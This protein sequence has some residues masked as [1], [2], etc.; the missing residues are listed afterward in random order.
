MPNMKFVNGLIFFVFILFCVAV[1]ISL[2]GG[3]FNFILGTY[4]LILSFY[5]TQERFLF[6]LG[7]GFFISLYSIFNFYQFFI[8]YL[9]IAY[10]LHLVYKKFFTH[11]S[12]F[13][14]LSMGFIAQLLYQIST[15]A[16]KFISNFFKD[17]GYYIKFDQ[18]F[19]QN[20]ILQQLEMCGFLLLACIF[21][22]P[23]YKK[24]KQIFIITKK[25]Y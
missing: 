5:D 17:G 24:F 16:L 3:H 18:I 15:V 14:I 8:I 11:Q 25:E 7:T 21:I 10:I 12:Y 9:I 13:S 4:V 1:Q 6:I 19:L 2:I 22:M 20:V 23:F